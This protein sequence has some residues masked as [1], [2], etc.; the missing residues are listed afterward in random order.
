MNNLESSICL[1]FRDESGQYIDENLWY[2]SHDWEDVSE[3]VHAR[4]GH[5]T[6]KCRRCGIEYHIDS[7][8]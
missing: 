5:H 1:K 3:W 8:G 6:Y 7:T 2:K 4:S